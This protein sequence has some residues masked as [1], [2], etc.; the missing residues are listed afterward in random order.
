VLGSSCTNTLAAGTQLQQLG[1][2]IG[3]TTA[4]G[5][6]QQQAGG[7]NMGVFAAPGIVSAGVAGSGSGKASGPPSSSGSNGSLNSMDSLYFEVS[8]H[9][10]IWNNPF[11]FVQVIRL[12]IY[13]VDMQ[14]KYNMVKTGWVK[15]SRSKWEDEKLPGLSGLE[16]APSLAGVER[17][18]SRSHRRALRNP[19]TSRCHISCEW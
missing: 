8:H 9:C 1:F 18:T 13:P 6:V 4:A 5:V 15:Y 11:F 14:R 12:Y 19:F 2:G 7:G 10:Q 16:C 17:C 3:G